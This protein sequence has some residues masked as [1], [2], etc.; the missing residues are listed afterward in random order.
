MVTPAGLL[1][2]MAFLLALAA[3]REMLVA[4]AAR[5]E[6]GERA[7]GAPTYPSHARISRSASEGAA[8]VSRA[9]WQRAA[10]WFDLPGRLRR[11][12]LGARLPLP[13]LLLG[14]F[15]GFCLGAILALGAAPAAPGHLAIVVAPALPAVGFFVPDALL[16]REARRR[17]RRLVAA[18]PDALDLL[19]VSV[20]SGRGPADGLA[21]LARAGEGPLAEEM[22]IAVAELSCG[23]PLSTALAALRAR[24]PGSEL[25]TLVASI[26]RSRRFGSPLADQLRRQASALRREG[27]RAVEERAARAAPKIQLVVALV[28]VPSVMLMIAAGLIANAGTLLSGF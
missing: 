23:S 6:A 14:K 7:P 21:Q 24:V 13:A 25:A 15:A 1:F 10:L 20:A 17:R 18:L 9:P 2:A 8:S 22:R 12:G 4:R 5:R 28:L 3:G 11:S 26:E 19:A 27:R 16:E